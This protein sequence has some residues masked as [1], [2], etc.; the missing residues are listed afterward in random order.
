MPPKL[1]AVLLLIIAAFAVADLAATANDRL[2]H[3]FATIE[4]ADRSPADAPHPTPPTS[5]ALS[6]KDAATPLIEDPPTSG[7]A[8]ILKANWQSDGGR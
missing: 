6:S 5:L 2:A 3:L 4:T 1:C 8:E 7:P